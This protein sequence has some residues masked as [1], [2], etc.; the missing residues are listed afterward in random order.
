MNQNAS[1][2]VPVQ[3]AVRGYIDSRLGLSHSGSVLSSNNTIGPGYVSRDGKLSMTAALNLAGNKII[4]V[5][6]PA[7]TGDATNRVYVDTQNFMNGQY[8]VTITSP[9][10]GDLIVYDTT[11]GSVTNTLSD[12]TIT[13]SDTNRIAVGNIIV[14]TGTFPF[15]GLTAGTYY[16]LSVSGNNIT[17][18]TSINGQPL[19]LA[20]AGT[21]STMTYICSRW[22]NNASPQ[23]SR[24]V[25]TGTL[26]ANASGTGTYATLVFATA[27]ATAPYSVGQQIIVSGVAPLDYNGSYEVNACT[28]TSVTYGSIANPCTA[29]GNLTQAGK[30]YGN[31]LSL[32]YNKLEA[33][34]TASL[35]SNTV[36]NSM[37]SS[38]AGIVQSKLA[39]QASVALSNVASSTLDQ[40]RLGL[41]EFNSDVFTATNGFVTLKNSVS[42]STGISYSK[43]Q[44]MATGNVLGNFSGSSAAP[45][46]VTPGVVVSQ[47]DGIKNASFTSAGAMTTNGSGTTTTGY[48]VTPISVSN[49]VSSIVKSDADKSVDVGSLKI[50]NATALQQT[51]VGPNVA[52]GI[53]TP[54]NHT[55]L[56]AYGTDA[57]NTVAKTTGVFDTSGGK[58]RASNISSSDDAT[59]TVV[60]MVGTYRVGALSTIDFAA[61]NA[62]LLTR[63]LSTGDAALEGTIL[64]TWK[65]S[66][67]STL[68]ATYADIAE[69]YEGDKEYESGT[70][71]VFGGDKEVTTTDQMN[72]VRS[73]GVVTT[74]PAYTMNADQT[75]IKVCIALAGRVPCKVVGRVKKGD[76]LTTS[77][78]PGCAVRV[79]TPTLGSIIGKA[80]EDKD[81]GEAGV[82]QVAV[83]RV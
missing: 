18:S 28:T 4:N 77:A 17:A 19:T 69:Y 43:I 35:H 59:G 57:S 33:T 56:N 50:L 25:L 48:S 41:S 42:A 60:N 23:G 1:D 52:I 78:T 22:R 20:D 6:N 2:I 53:T 9:S 7:N 37:I 63:S 66:G 65:L 40:T 68:Q 8:D 45:G 71:L 21:G 76:M 44:F 70:V 12:G 16:V 79:T 10:A 75:G 73:A 54:G 26:A 27:Q 11:V 24:V 34:L 55:F 38:T 67:A 58:L 15:S 13:L 64:G 80:L 61:N 5:G 49:A 36:V 72:D 39:M 32:K 83:G 30:I 74:N 51:S 46:E 3:S 31:Q 14:L 62:I 47:G 82:I 81:Y 29:T